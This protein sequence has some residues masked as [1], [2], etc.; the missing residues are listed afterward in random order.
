M[1]DDLWSAR[2]RKSSYSS[3]SGQCVEVATGVPGSIGVRDSK[4]PHSANLMFLPG[5]WSRFL[6]SI[7]TGDIPS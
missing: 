7:K 2:W 6:T 5:E 4:D 1:A 3:D